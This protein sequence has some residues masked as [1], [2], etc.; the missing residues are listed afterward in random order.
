MCMHL[1]SVQDEKY[2]AEIARINE[3]FCQWHHF[4]KSL[5]GVSVILGVLVYIT[6]C[7][8][9]SNTVLKVRFTVKNSKS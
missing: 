8:C 6:H 2:Q 5:G 1:M 4:S 9:S 7:F 3:S